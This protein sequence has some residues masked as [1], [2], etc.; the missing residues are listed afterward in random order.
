MMISRE[1]IRG[2]L[3][4]LVDSELRA[5]GEVLDLYRLIV[6]DPIAVNGVS[7]V[8]KKVTYEKGDPM[9]SDNIR[10]FRVKSNGVVAQINTGLGFSSS[11]GIKMSR[12]MYTFYLPGISTVPCEYDNPVE[13][14]SLTTGFGPVYAKVSG[15]ISD[16][17]V[18]CMV[19]LNDWYRMDLLGVSPLQ[20]FYSED[21]CSKEIA[22]EKFALLKS[23]NA[24][25]NDLICSKDNG[26]D[27]FGDG[28]LSSAVEKMNSFPG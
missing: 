5:P 8:I 12:K 14:T 11:Y 21:V 23:L 17:V 7:T 20:E 2:R 16:L 4:D 15:F 19:V 22:S 24:G 26:T 18:D 10:S 25:A 6:Q 28:T 3:K 27:R 9:Y 13:V 1:V